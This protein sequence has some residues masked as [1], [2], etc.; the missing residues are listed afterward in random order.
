MLAVVPSRLRD[1][2][3]GFW[4]RSER[5]DH[6][7]D[8]ISIH[9]PNPL[10]FP[11]QLLAFIHFLLLLLLYSCVSGHCDIYQECRMLSFSTTTISG[12]LYLIQSRGPSGYLIPRGFWLSPS[13]SLVHPYVST[14]VPDA[15][16]HTSHTGSG[17]QFRR[18][19]HISSYI[20]VVSACGIHLFSAR[21]YCLFPVLAH[22]AS[23]TPSCLS[24]FTSMSV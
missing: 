11:C 12:R 22:S 16:G 19:C 3:W 2:L 23:Y 13:L 14:I 15:A 5:T 10:E 9:F 6:Y 18:L 8:F 7:R 1:F 20:P 4:C 17:G 24:I 21:L